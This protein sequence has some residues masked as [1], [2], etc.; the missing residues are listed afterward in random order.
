VFNVANHFTKHKSEAITEAHWKPIIEQKHVLC[1][2]Y[3]KVGLTNKGG[4]FCYNLRAM[5]FFAHQVFIVANHLT[6]HKINI[7]FEACSACI[8][9][10]ST[11]LQVGKPRIQFPVLWL[12][13]NWSNSSSRNIKLGS[14]QPLTEKRTKNLL[15][16][17]W[18]PVCKSENLTANSVSRL[19]SKC[20]SLGVSQSYG[21]P[22]PLTGIAITSMIL[23]FS[24][25]WLLRL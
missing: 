12:V 22:R 6:K 24:L 23:N 3:Y 8:V 4:I 18:W 16:G 15:V 1:C 11:M 21:F 7:A 9:G 14:I 10:W 19:S 17:K 5:K 25:C 13:F 2:G 20:G